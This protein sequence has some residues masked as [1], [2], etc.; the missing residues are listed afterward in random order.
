L[1]LY[2]ITGRDLREHDYAAA[3]AHLAEAARIATAAQDPGA[4]A[5]VVRARAHLYWR[6]MLMAESADEYA[7][8]CAMLEQAG[9][10]YKLANARTWHALA[11]VALG[12]FAE[13]DAI[14]VGL[15]EYCE[16][17]G[18]PGALFAARRA[19]GYIDVA[20]S[21]DLEQYNAFAA[22]DL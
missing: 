19:R 10:L 21:G 15:A 11:L 17:V 3:L 1:A 13:A 14:L 9:E 6:H 12:R 20:R 4:Q 2:A 8:A 18:D 7:R 16:R 5:D 22:E